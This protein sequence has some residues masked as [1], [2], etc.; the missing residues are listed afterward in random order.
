MIL[1]VNRT[2]KTNS[3]TE[4]QL[5]INGQ[6]F[7]DT[8]ENPDRG[9]VQ[10]MS[11]DQVKKIKVPKETCIPSGKYNVILNCKSAYADK[12]SRRWYYQTDMKGTM[13]RI[14][15]VTGFAGILI[16]YGTSTAWTEGCLLVGKRSGAGRLAA[17][18]NVIFKLYSI[19]AAARAKNEKVSIQINQGGTTVAAGAVDYGSSASDIGSG[20]SQQNQ[21]NFAQRAAEGQAALEK[22]R[23]EATKAV[24][25]SKAEFDQI[26][27]AI[28]NDPNYN[29]N[30][31]DIELEDVEVPQA[32]VTEK[33]SVLQDM[34]TEV[35]VA[36]ESPNS[37]IMKK[38][39]SS[40][41]DIPGLDVDK[42]TEN[43]VMSMDS[44]KSMISSYTDMINFKSSSKDLGEAADPEA[45]KEL[46]DED[47]AL[48]EDEKVKQV[49]AAKAAT[50]PQVKESINKIKC[51]YHELTSGL[52][53]IENAVKSFMSNQLVPSTIVAG[54]ATGTA[55]PLYFANQATSFKAQMNSILIPLTTVALMMVQE[56]DKIK[57]KLP[58]VVYQSI[59]MIGTTQS[60]INTIP[61]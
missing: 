14:E 61:G 57:F 52:E 59:V 21:I 31:W 27:S 42:I 25:E 37:S 49:E 35:P 10:G 17:D 54:S 22:E 33:Q 28:M 40:L 13:P 23:A 2:T 45:S 46:T 58:D 60:L 18:K 53:N 48:L 56:S 4:G 50:R 41:P 47:K 9:L 7:C 24:Q 30:D 15:P 11:A 5:L 39:Q 19:F 36:A 8:L 34:K 38:L 29:P 12:P 44:I 1:T 16:H 43:L 55:N 51:L 32:T 6:Y 26:L 3:Y 20:D